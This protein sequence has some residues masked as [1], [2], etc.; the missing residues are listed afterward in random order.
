METDEKTQLYLFLSNIRGKF[1]GAKVSSTRPLNVSYS[2]T[3]HNEI[4]TIQECVFQ[5]GK[6]QKSHSLSFG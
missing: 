2:V 5:D 3:K 4:F 6:D 1:G